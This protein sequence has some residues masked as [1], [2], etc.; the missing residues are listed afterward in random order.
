M[1][2]LHVRQVCCPVCSSGVHG[3]RR[4]YL[5][6]QC[7]S[8]SRPLLLIPNGSV[9]LQLVPLIAI[10]RLA[11]SIYACLAIA[12]L[13][14]PVFT[15]KNCMQLFGFF[16]VAHGAID[17][18]SACLMSRTGIVE[19]PSRAPQQPNRNVVIAISFSSG[20]LAVLLGAAGLFLSAAMR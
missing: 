1:R 4:L 16:G 15:P 17:L 5:P 7:V 13:L 12:A 6:F 9:G 2:R 14:V 18:A 19:R 20:S 8:C 11:V 3:V 10:A